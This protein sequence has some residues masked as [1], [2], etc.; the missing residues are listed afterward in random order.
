MTCRTDRTYPWSDNNRLKSIKYRFDCNGGVHTTEV[1]D[2][3]RDRWSSVIKWFNNQTKPWNKHGK[4]FKVKDCTDLTLVEVKNLNTLSGWCGI[5]EIIPVSG[6]QAIEK[7]NGTRSL[8]FK[9]KH[10]L[11][12]IRH[13][14]WYHLVGL[15]PMIYFFKDLMRDS[16]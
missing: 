2:G 15:K 16:E 7:F 4:V 6:V 3:I 11:S 12:I 5:S 9:D 10:I 14:F 13:T 8:M 1:H